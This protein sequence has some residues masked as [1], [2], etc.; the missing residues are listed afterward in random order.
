MLRHRSALAVADL[1][2]SS[3]H[4]S[5]SEAEDL[6]F[7]L[8]QAALLTEPWTV[9]FV[10]SLC[11]AGYFFA[12][13]ATTELNS[14]EAEEASRECR[15]CIEGLWYLGRK[16]DMAFL[17][18]RFLSDMLATMKHDLTVPELSRYAS[19]LLSGYNEGFTGGLDH[20]N[21]DSE[22]GYDLSINDKIDDHAG[23]ADFMDVFPSCTI[24]DKGRDNVFTTWLPESGHLLNSFP[25]IPLH[26]VFGLK[27]VD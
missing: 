22:G 18:A 25:S 12:D 13:I 7:A 20:I 5:R 11:R 23:I 6:H 16:S 17:A 8:N 4:G 10:R 24:P 14:L 21:L 2:R 1:S 19:T 27:L 26:D 9:V 3:I 15:D